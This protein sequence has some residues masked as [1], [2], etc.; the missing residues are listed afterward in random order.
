MR[1]IHRWWTIVIPFLVVVQIT[2]VGVGAFHS[3]T[4]VDDRFGSKVVPAC[5]P[6]CGKSFNESF[7][8]WFEPHVA[9]DAGAATPEFH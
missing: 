9:G 6:A 8:N 5:D 7:N 4:S 2:L 1:A 3:A